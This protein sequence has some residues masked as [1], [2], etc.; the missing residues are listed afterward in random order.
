LTATPESSKTMARGKIINKYCQVKKKRPASRIG[1]ELSKRIEQGKKKAPEEKKNAKKKKRK[2]F[3][4]E[5]KNKKKHIIGRA[6]KKKQQQRRKEEGEMGEKKEKEHML[7]CS[8]GVPI[9][10]R[11]KYNTRKGRKGGAPPGKGLLDCVGKED[12]RKMRSL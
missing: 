9:C 10:P 6:K 7:H 4:L 5:A 2:A 3:I 11:R 8:G 12:A 1:G